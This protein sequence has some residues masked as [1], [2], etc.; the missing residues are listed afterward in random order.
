MWIAV[1]R[2]L[3]V[4]YLGGVRIECFVRCISANSVAGWLFGFVPNP[5]VE[6]VKEDK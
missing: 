5:F 2:E 3:I 6:V 1:D 4:K